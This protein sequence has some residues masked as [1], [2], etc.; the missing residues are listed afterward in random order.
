MFGRNLFL[1]RIV[2]SWMAAHSGQMWLFV[3]SVRRQ[4]KHF[5][6]GLD[7]ALSIEKT[8]CDENPML[9]KPTWL[10]KAKVDKHPKNS[11]KK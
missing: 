5:P 9:M 11:K 10:K 2:L 8:S 3:R 4:K 1:S 6:L 7:M